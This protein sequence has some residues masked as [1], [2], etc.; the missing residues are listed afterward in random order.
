M[1]MIRKNPKTHL[2]TRWIC[3]PTL[4]LSL[5]VVAPL[6]AVP[7]RIMPLGDSITA[8]YTDNPTWNVP[9][10]FG[11]RSRLYTLLTNAGYDFVFVGG[12]LE[13]YNNAF[14]DPTH[15]GTVSPTLDLRTFGQNGH[16][17]YGGVTI[18]T[19]TTNVASYITSDTPD[20]ILLMIGINGIGTSSPSQLDTLTNSIFTST[21]T[22]KLVTA[23]IIPKIP[24]TSLVVDYNTYIR[25]TLLPKYL[26]LG[27]SITTVDLYANFLTNPADN[28][29]INTALY[30]N[31]INHPTATGYSAMADTWFKGILTIIPPTLPVLSQTQ[32]LSSIAPAATIGSFAQPPSP[33]TE[34]LT[35]SLIT[36]TGDTD[37][38]KF[39]IS[40]NQLR[41]ATYNF[42]SDP[43]GKTYSI[44]VRAT[45][46]I[47]GRVGER[48]FTL[49]PIS[50]TD[51]DGLPDSWE[52]AKAGNITSLTATGDF[53]H[54]GLTDLQEYTLSTG[55]YPNI[56]PTK[57]DTDGDGLSD[58]EEIHGSPPRPP[59]DP[60]KAD[61]DGDLISDAA[62][63]NTG[64]YVSAMKTGTNPTIADTDGD[65]RSDG[66]ELI[67]GSNP[68][69]SSSPG[70]TSLATVNSTT[71]LA[72]AG[73]VSSA[74]LLQGLT[75]T[76]AVHTGWNLGNNASPTKLNDGVLGGTY[77]TSPPTVEGAWSESSGSVST[78]TLPA[79]NGS[80]WDLNS[81]VTFAAWNGAGFGN[82]HYDVAVRRVWE[83]TFS[84]IASINYQPFSVTGT[85]GTKVTI[86]H[87]SGMLARGVNAIRFTMLSTNGNSGR[88]VYREFD[89]FGTATVPPAPSTS[90][91]QDSRTS[92]SE[93]SITW[94]SWPA[95]TYRVESSQNLK[96]WSVLSPTYPSGGVTTRFIESLVPLSRTKSFYRVSAN[97]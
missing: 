53:D 59:T 10:E 71:E 39:S 11:Y 27:K 94:L 96:D 42:N 63:D 36:G 49:S 18:P 24:Y 89:V 93:V 87:P 48:V 60:T 50:D 40:S 81:I 31:A 32:F 47:G 9:F 14:G 70:S 58:G 44:R 83:T 8:G 80:G 64:I 7:L 46:N 23:Q 95:K 85:G 79:G 69:S 25:N 52:M 16:R 77:I 26:G 5:V 67:E 61:T 51:G 91:L 75:G 41:A 65:G 12:S 82:Q 34:T 73:Q 30:A 1:P 97:P 86:T 74:D 19:T 92:R 88:S 84:T 78:F 72:Y 56:D 55:A 21:P 15:G 68:M 54:D 13:P 43:V 4:V 57:Y 3:I 22:V 37:N 90:G 2:T 28:T 45:G 38:A 66:L 33:S 35:F 62:E 17:G 29:S 20:I 76:N 6:Y